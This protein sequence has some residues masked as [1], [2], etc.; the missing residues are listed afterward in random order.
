MAA[1]TS[2]VEEVTSSRMPGPAFL[3]TDSVYLA[4]GTLVPFR[5]L[6]NTLTSYLDLVVTFLMLPWNFGVTEV[7]NWGWGARFCSGP[8]HWWHGNSIFRKQ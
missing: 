1:S 3:K 7:T 2:C 4:S 8:T 5:K 6:E